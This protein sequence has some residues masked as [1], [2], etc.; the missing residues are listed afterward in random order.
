MCCPFS[1]QGL[2]RTVLL[3]GTLNCLASWIKAAS[4]R[5]D[6]YVVTMVGQTLAGITQAFILAVPARLAA[7]W[8][9]AGEVG[10][11]CAIGVFGNQVRVRAK[12]L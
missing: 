10:T 8:F 11:A 1:V 9:G 6:L 2:R 7:V 3:A 4:A 5:R 12:Y